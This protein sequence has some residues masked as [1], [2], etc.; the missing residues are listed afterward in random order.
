[1]FL[2]NKKGIGALLTINIIFVFLGISIFLFLTLFK[3]TIIVS[4]VQTITKSRE[5]LLFL[6]I[7]N[8]QY[9]YGENFLLSLS[10][11]TKTNQEIKN[12]IIKFN[13]M[14][15]PKESSPD[16]YSLP[17]TSV[18]NH[19]LSTSDDYSSPD[20]Y[21]LPKTSVYYY[22]NLNGEEITIKYLS[23]GKCYVNP[24]RCSEY[25]YISRFLIPQIYDGRTFVKEGVFI[26][27]A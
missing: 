9:S 18:Y 17:K 20:Y 5:S 13:E 23:N 6:S 7:I 27:F 12:Y 25:T 19:N 21:S 8:N 2:G 22:Y 14:D 11:E 4:R 1:M 3:Q 15:I 10:N 26:S 16:Y 24:L